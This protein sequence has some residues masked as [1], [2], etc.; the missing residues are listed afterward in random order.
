MKSIY[1]THWDRCGV[2]TRQG[3]MLAGHLAGPQ[4]PASGSNALT[5]IRLIERRWLRERP[6]ASTEL[7]T[8]GKK[9]ALKACAA[10]TLKLSPVLEV[11]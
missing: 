1:L 8:R 10:L 9:A 6:D 5:V 7:T 11:A 4:P 2:T 3:A